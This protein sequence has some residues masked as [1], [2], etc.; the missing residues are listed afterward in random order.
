MA[1]TIQH[2]A[3]GRQQAHQTQPIQANWEMVLVPLFGKN[4]VKTGD[5]EVSHCES[6]SL[7]RK[8]ATLNACLILA[9]ELNSEGLSW[10]SALQIQHQTAC[11]IPACCCFVSVIALG[12]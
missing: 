5:E 12:I 10:V 2:V 7:F 9:N 11:V 3:I 4:G 8:A 1:K 6:G